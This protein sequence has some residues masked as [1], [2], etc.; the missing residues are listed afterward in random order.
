MAGQRPRKGWIYKINPYRV[1]LTCRSSHTYFYS[2]TEPSEVQCQHSSCSEIINSSRILRGEH[3]YI[4][5]ESDQFLDNEKYIQTFTSIPLT[6]KTTYAGLSTVY[7][8]TNTIKNGLD[9]TS[10]ALVHQICTVDGNCFKDGA[11]N[12]LSR[13]GQLSKEDKDAIEETLL[14]YLDISREPNDDWLR[15]NASPKLIK[16]IFDFLPS[17]QKQETLENLFDGWDS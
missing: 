1:S 10:Y 5:W 9:K 7:P 4:I 2:L 12:W 8:I 17:E 3:P 16:Q 11:N 14:Y 6:S 13:I 15:D